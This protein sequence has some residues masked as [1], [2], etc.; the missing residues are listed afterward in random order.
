[1]RALTT[2]AS[3]HASLFTKRGETL[4]LSNISQRS[5]T[6][7]YLLRTLSTRTN[8]NCFQWSTDRRNAMVS[9]N[10]SKIHL[11]P[12]RSFSAE[13]TEEDSDAAS[14]RQVNHIR[15]VAIVAHVD[16]G[17]TT[18]VDEL[19]RCASESGGEKG[20]AL[21]MDCGDLERERGI[22]I[23]SKVTRLDYHKV[24]S[25][26]IKTINVVDTVSGFINR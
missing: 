24:G 5:I 12:F 18:I 3:N 26:G 15:N 25:D 23:T 8:G 11:Q 20:A 2:G 21:V 22:T 16:H 14:I 19:L 9:N 17:K 13:S 4:K 7:D 10:K 1:M 6:S